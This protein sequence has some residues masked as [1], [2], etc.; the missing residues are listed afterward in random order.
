MNARTKAALFCGLCRLCRLL[1]PEIGCRLDS[2]KQLADQD[3]LPHRE[4]ST[5]KLALTAKKFH[6]CHSW[7]KAA[8]QFSCFVNSFP[9]MKNSTKMLPENRKLLQEIESCRSGASN[10][11]TAFRWWSRVCA[12]AGVLSLWQ[13]N[14]IR[15]CP[16]DRLRY[17]RCFS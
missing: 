17:H 11:T 8:Q 13:P 14:Q 7:R 16:S 6:C 9:V 10:R 15:S 3:L 5:Q 4:P 2:R 1:S 12:A